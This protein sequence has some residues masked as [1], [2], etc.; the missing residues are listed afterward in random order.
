MLQLCTC[1]VIM[2]HYHNIMTLPYYIIVTQLHYHNVIKLIY[3]SVTIV[4]IELYTEHK[5]YIKH[6]LHVG[7]Y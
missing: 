6:E 2:L 5:L 3:M 1:I 4:Y 7:I